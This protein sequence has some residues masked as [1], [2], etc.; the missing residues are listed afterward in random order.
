MNFF[1]DIE[2]TQLTRRIA[3]P[4][5]SLFARTSRRPHRSAAEIARAAVREILG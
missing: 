3:R 4:P 1:T 2:Q 5:L